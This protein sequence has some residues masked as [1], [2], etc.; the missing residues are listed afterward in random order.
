MENVAGLISVIMLTYNR[1]NFVRRAIESVLAQTYRNFEFIIIDN[2]STDDSGKI[3]DEYDIDSRVRVVHS[4]RETIGR[5]RNRGLDLAAGDWIAFVD[6]DDYLESD[7][8]T[9]LME[10]ATNNAADIAICGTTYLVNNEK[11]VLNAEESIIKLLWRKHYSNGFPAKLFKK[12]LFDE[13]K[14]PIREKYEDI[15]LMYRVL[16]KA[17]C[18]A[19]HG[20]LKYH[21]T[22]HSGNNSAATTIEGQI[23]A[24]YISEY[25]KVYN[26]RTNWLCQ[27][28]P[29]N[30]EYW[31]YFN[32]SFQISMV[33]KIKKNNLQDCFK[34]FEAMR[35]E[36]QAHRDEFVNSKWLQH[37]ECEWVVTYL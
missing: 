23:T 25:R 17:N 22:R 13:L 5:G 29:D 37:F 35:Q 14:F 24:Q 16:A 15:Y 28:Y 36:L 27:H 1:Q 3:A 10:L 2:G 4:A 30:E 6:D 32:W 12:T 7:Y 19:Y 21:V 11:L 9:F 34:H 31:N 18:V 26:E 33:N 8:L 20:L